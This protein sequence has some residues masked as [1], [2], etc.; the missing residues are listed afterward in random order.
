MSRSLHE[1]VD[2]VHESNFFA[3]KVKF[4]ETLAD[5]NNARER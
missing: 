5:L 1:V 3:D 2:A 4:H